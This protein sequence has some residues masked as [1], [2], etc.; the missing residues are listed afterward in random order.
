MQ[1]ER[2]SYSF[3]RIGDFYCFSTAAVL[4][5]VF[6]PGLATA[7]FPILAGL[8][9][10]GIPQRLAIA[11]G[12]QIAVRCPFLANATLL[13][14][15][16]VLTVLPIMHLCLRLSGDQLR[17]KDTVGRTNTVNKVGY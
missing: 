10:R 7:L 17:Q 14:L 9:K 15:V 2:E 8:P 4:V 6:S 11:A 5:A 1:A 16:V 3:P 12:R 13:L